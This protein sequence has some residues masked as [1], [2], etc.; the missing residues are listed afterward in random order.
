MS[1][2]F[3][4]L[5][6]RIELKSQAKD[7]SW[8]VFLVIILDGRRKRYALG[9]R[10]LRENWDAKSRTV[11][12]Q[13]PQSDQKN[14]IIQDALHRAQKIAVD[15]RTHGDVIGFS[16]FEN[17]FFSSDTSSFIE[18]WRDEMEKMRPQLAPGTYKHHKS[19]LKKLE[20]FRPDLQFS[21]VNLDFLNDFDKHLRR[22]YGNAYNTRMANFNKVRRYVNLAMAH[23]KMARNPFDFFSIG[24][25][26]AH[27]VVLT[28]H[29]VMDLVK[30]WASKELSP[31]HQRALQNF[32][33]GC[34]TGL[35]IS[36]VYAVRKSQIH[37]STLIFTPQKTSS[38][39]KVI[40]IPLS[41]MARHFI[42]ETDQDLLADQLSEQKT[43]EYLKVIAARMGWNMNLHFHAARHT[44]ATIY[45]E[46]G[47]SVEVLKRILGHSKLATTMKYVHISQA[48]MEH[49]MALFDSQ[50]WNS[51]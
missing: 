20:N 29:E 27:R 28:R 8:M 34:F 26:D 49:E 50:K 24:F 42:S 9:I 43:N 45:L 48:R 23:G 25:Q 22:K 18:F 39:S 21:D 33:L 5:R 15:L 31:G 14:L 10:V 7:G 40:Q 35:R 32:L 6:A 51:E 38:R 37:G 19:V 46:L 30:L 13:D 36:D 4:N 17:R 1:K 41:K 16:D 3:S 47:G 2:G 12:K 11:K 44:F